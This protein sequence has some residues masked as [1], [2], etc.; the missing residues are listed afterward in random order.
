M[1]DSDHSFE[2]DNEPRFGPY[3]QFWE[4][5]GSRP[6]LQFV[7][8]P[9]DGHAMIQLEED[10]PEEVRQ[11][12]RTA[13]GTVIVERYQLDPHDPRRLRLIYVG[14]EVID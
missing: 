10:P 3:D 1:S 9:L 5:L 4:S 13:S 8:G 2:S 14:Y 6:L 12:R 11:S 7:G